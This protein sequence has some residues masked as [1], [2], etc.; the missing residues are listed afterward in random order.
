VS[1]YEI[2]LTVSADASDDRLR[3]WAAAHGVRY[4][5]IALDRGDHASQPMVSLLADGVQERF[6]TQRCHRVGR[7][8]AAAELAALLDD[9]RARSGAG[10]SV[11]EVEEEWVLVGDN[12]ALNTGWFG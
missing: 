9:L 10:W 7:A 12:P 11:A 5:R 2:H 3:S 8:E 1:R 4:T 6:L